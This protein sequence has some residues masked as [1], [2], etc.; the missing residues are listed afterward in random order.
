[1][2]KDLPTPAQSESDADQ[3]RRRNYEL[4]I[5]NKIAEALN[6]SVD[7]GQTLNA[8]LAQVAELLDLE[9]GWVW[10]LQ[11]E[12]GASYLAAAQ[13]LPPGLV[14]N[15]SL[16]EGSC[17]CLDTFRAGDL[18]GAANVNVVTCSRL[19]KLVDGTGGLR[20]HASIPLYAH[21]KKLGVL[22]VASSDWRELS[23]EDLRLLYTIGDLLSI[24]IERAR[25]FNQSA[26]LG[27]VQERNRLA[28]ELH[29]TLAQTLA[30]IALQLET[31]DALME[32][33]SELENSRRAVQ[34]ALNLTRT[35]LEEA[36][37][38][39]MD[40]RA[41]PL[42]G[43]SLPDALADLAKEAAQSSVMQVDFKVTGAA[44][45]LPVRVEAGIYRIAQEALAN[46]VQHAQA[47]R[48]ALLLTILPEQVKLVIEDNGRGFDP[49]RASSGRFG[50]IG[51][52]ER[53]RI[54]GGQME[55]LSSP[56]EGT[57]VEV[58][59]PLRPTIQA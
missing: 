47:D 41:A 11:E 45:P 33:G 39:V 32:T 5:L 55:L 18:E 14:H 4:S 22:N 13:N 27:A 10:L 54:L 25:L 42:E 21:G 31:A 36:R 46:V 9:T 57:R 15:P 12:T 48:A 49:K 44:N 51:L 7:L 40:L 6:H 29:D 2:E 56:G 35:S 1:M 37:R 50:L 19:K 26:E 43:R 28:R 24:A 3:L 16:M 52:N 53:T 23:P 59:V 30:G 38:S 8:A 58:T 17:Y 20:Y 34:E